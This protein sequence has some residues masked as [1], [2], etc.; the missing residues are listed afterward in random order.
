MLNYS[1]SE[2]NDKEFEELSIDLLSKNLD[3]QIERFK[4][5]QDQ[6]IDGRFF[7]IDSTTIIQCK[8]Y[9]KSGISQLISKLKTDELPKIQKLNTSRYILTTSCPL[10]PNDKAKIKENLKPFIICESDILGAEN[11]N[12]LLKKYPSVERQYY[13][14]WLS[15]TNVLDTILNNALLGRSSDYLQNTIVSKAHLLIQTDNFDKALTQLEKNHTLIITGAPGVGK[16][17]L[18]NQ[19]SLYL[20]IEKEYE[21]YCIDEDLKEAEEIYQQGKNQ[22]FYFDDFL[23]ANILEALGAHNRDSKIIQFIRRVKHDPTKRFILTSRSHI[24]SQK[25]FQ[26]ERYDQA[27]INQDRYELEISL[28]SNIDKAKIL[29]NHLWH[30]NLPQEF[31]DELYLNSSHQEKRYETIVR[32]PNYNP[33][34]IEFI[35]DYDHFQDVPSHLYWEHIQ[36]NL[37]NPQNL[38][39]QVIENDIDE[40][41]KYILLAIALNKNSITERE[42]RDF[43]NSLISQ[44]EELHN[45]KTFRNTIELLLDSLLKSSLNYSTEKIYT[46]FNPSIADYLINNYLSEYT[47][48]EKI[49][50]HLYSYQYSKYL[51]DLHENDKISD[52][53]YQRLI[54]SKINLFIEQQNTNPDD[55]EIAYLIHHWE[56][57]DF[58]NINVCRYLTALG[59]TILL[60]MG[61]YDTSRLFGIIPKL[62]HNKFICPTTSHSK[63]I[64][65]ISFYFLEEQLVDPDFL[66]LAPIINLLSYKKKETIKN[67]SKNFTKHIIENDLIT[68]YAEEES[69]LS[70]ISDI[71]DAYVSFI[72]EIIFE[73]IMSD[74]L[75]EIPFDLL[76]DDLNELAKSADIDHLLSNLDKEEDHDKERFYAGKYGNSDYQKTSTV[77]PITDLFQRH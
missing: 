31:I 3:R 29:Y 74:F 72:E 63:L 13:K 62:I 24:L 1:F 26:N 69:V 52:T 67:F 66:G 48:L 73:W 68:Y 59:Q 43:Y 23:G 64:N 46:L 38:W 5:G 16:T 42:L 28:L 70:N 20:C 76:E 8:H 2:L 30:S 54:Q 39:K 11:L 27:K 77:N 12:N 22:L 36:E 45:Q 14:L 50:S 17:T 37:T 60:S 15:S 6:G 47:Y 10:S 9:L 18:A 51:F 55:L 75:K 58:E 41:S 71:H 53:L 32:H 34:L 61:R 49:N 57:I 44:D 4:T 40:L 21:F 35:T 25:S 56:Y 7:D 65:F 19:L 33:R